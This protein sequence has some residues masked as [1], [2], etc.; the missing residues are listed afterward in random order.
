MKGEGGERLDELTQC[1]QLNC[2]TARRAIRYQLSVIDT[3]QRRR[4]RGR[5]RDRGRA[6]ID[7]ALLPEVE[8]L[9]KTKQKNPSE[10]NQGVYTNGEKRR[11]GG[12]E[13]LRS[14]SP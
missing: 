3:M 2:A 7:D 14:K 6:E 10:S 12:G 1:K 11:E 9:Y 4:T 13:N 8:R 5:H